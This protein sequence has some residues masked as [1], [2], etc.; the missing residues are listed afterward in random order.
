MFNKIR[1]KAS[2]LLTLDQ[3]KIDNNKL[4]TTDTSDMK[5][6]FQTWFWN[7]NSNKT[8]SDLK[9]EDDDEDNDENLEKEYPKTERKTSP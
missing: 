6:N 8:D 4:S 5:D 1:S 7:E 3:Y 2:L 9:K